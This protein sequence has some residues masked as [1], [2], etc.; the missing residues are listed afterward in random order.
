MTDNERIYYRDRADVR[1]FLREH[2]MSAYDLQKITKELC[3][4]GTC[5]FFVQHYTKAREALDWGHCCKGNIQHSKKVSTAS[6]GSWEDGVEE[7]DDD[8]DRE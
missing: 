6:C 3:S 1:Q 2:R 4:C 5:R 7:D 8:T